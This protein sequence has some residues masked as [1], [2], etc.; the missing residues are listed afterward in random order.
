MGSCSIKTDKNPNQ[1]YSTAIRWI[2][3]VDKKNQQVI[4]QNGKK[5]AIQVKIKYTL[6]ADDTNVRFYTHVMEFT[7]KKGKNI[8]SKDFIG[9]SD[10][11]V[12]LEWGAQTFETRYINNTDKPEW[13]ETAYL[14][15]HEKHQSKYQLKLCVMDKDINADDQLGT[16]YIAASDVFKNCGGGKAWNMDVNLR[17][18]PVDLDRGLLEFDKNEKFK[19]WGDL[20][21]QIK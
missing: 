11:Y 15:V 20:E 12:K 1:H 4:G 8:R 5:S 14:F 17:A 7:V 21:V 10:P 18:V 13:N 3:L 16:G 2:P 9:K 19:V 6:N